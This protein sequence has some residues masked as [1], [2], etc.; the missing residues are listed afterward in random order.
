M[1]KIL[2]SPVFLKQLQFIHAETL[3]GSRRFQMSCVACFFSRFITFV[4]QPFWDICNW[5]HSWFPSTGSV[6]QV[7][8][9]EFCV[10]FWIKDFFQN[11]ECDISFSKSSGKT[12]C[13]GMQQSSLPYPWNHLHKSSL[14]HDR[15][16]GMRNS[17][18]GSQVARDKR[19]WM[20][21]QPTQ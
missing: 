18:R 5:F 10:L 20:S 19:S 14:S 15:E 6:F 12:Q 16:G 7:G 21:Y 17:W 8:G 13:V 1:A 3:T 2:A 9:K 4:S 11:L